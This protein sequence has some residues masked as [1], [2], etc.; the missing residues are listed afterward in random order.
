MN[1]I[2]IIANKTMLP[3]S[4]VMAFINTAPYRYK[5]YYLHK[6]NGG[7]R[8]IAQPARELKIM[9]RLILKSLSSNLPI[10]DNAFAYIEKKSIKLNA[11]KHKKNSYFLKMDF[12]DFFNSIK[13]VDL[14]VTLTKN[15]F[16]DNKGDLD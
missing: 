8:E 3:S 15:G 2:E 9:Q 14:I 4:T 5:K 13:P 16:V 12:E 6:K 10:H 11:L 1:I 7:L